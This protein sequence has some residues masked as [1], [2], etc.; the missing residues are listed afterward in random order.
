MKTNLK[1]TIYLELICKIIKLSENSLEEN[2]ELQINKEDGK[3]MNP[4]KYV[5]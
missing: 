3:E 1:W 4:G 2:P 5:W